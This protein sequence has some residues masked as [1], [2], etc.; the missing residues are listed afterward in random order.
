MLLLSAIL[1]GTIFLYHA[2]WERH[3]DMVLLKEEA[4]LRL[5]AGKKILEREIGH[6]I[7]D[8]RSLSGIPCLRK[9]IHDPQNPQVLRSTASEFQVFARHKIWYDQVRLLDHDGQEIIRVNATENGPVI[10]PPEALQDK[11]QRYYFSD[12]RKLQKGEIYLSPL[13]LNVEHGE[14]ETPHKPTLRLA[15]RLLTIRA[16]TGALS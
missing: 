5:Q 14:I 10:V 6:V 4:D 11:S 15:A 2:H 9:W 1:L 16:A 12:L 13:D 8:V 7:S 3:H